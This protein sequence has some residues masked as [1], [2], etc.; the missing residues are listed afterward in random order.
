MRHIDANKL[1]LLPITIRSGLVGKSRESRSTDWL[2]SGLGQ[3]FFISSTKNFI[4][5]F[6]SDGDSR[7]FALS[8]D[9][10]EGDRPTAV[11]SV[12]Q[13]SVPNQDHCIPTPE[14]MNGSVKPCWY[15]VLVLEV[16]HYVQSIWKHLPT[17]TAES[18]QII[19]VQV[20]NGSIN[21]CI[22]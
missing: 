17:S 14:M 22:C 1:I 6:L 8:S 15:L 16:L 12:W 20:S 11:P 5:V 19:Y 7:L 9:S 18:K 3:H 2:K 10:T 21:Y 4:T 13:I